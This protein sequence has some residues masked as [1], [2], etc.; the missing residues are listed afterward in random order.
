[1]NICWGK[2]ADRIHL[3]LSEQFANDFLVNLK[4]LIDGCDPSAAMTIYN[5]MGEILNANISDKNDEAIQS[6]WSDNAKPQQ[7]DNVTPHEYDESDE[8]DE[9]VIET[10]NHS[11]DGGFQSQPPSPVAIAWHRRIA[12]HGSW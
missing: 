11:I 1:M 3:I 12:R 7:F 6:K 10:T 4:K 9:F 8:F 2:C 5:R